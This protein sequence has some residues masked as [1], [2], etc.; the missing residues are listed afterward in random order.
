MQNITCPGYHNY[1]HTS[2]RCASE[3]DV[4]AATEFESYQVAAS[5]RQ[6]SKSWSLSADDMDWGSF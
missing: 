1:P 3:L 4:S 5:H 2:Q 6:N